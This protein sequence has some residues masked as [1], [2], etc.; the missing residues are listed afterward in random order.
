MDI[1][2]VGVVR[3][4]PRLVRGP[5]KVGYHC[6]VSREDEY[7]GPKYRVSDSNSLRPVCTP[8]NYVITHAILEYN[9]SWVVWER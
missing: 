6:L 8:G 7:V 4:E 5:S 1:L 3:W 9:V 2:A